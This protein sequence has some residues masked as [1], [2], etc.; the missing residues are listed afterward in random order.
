LLMGSRCATDRNWS[1]N[2]GHTGNTDKQGDLEARLQPACHTRSSFSVCSTLCNGLQHRAVL[3]LCSQPPQQL[4]LCCMH[5]CMDND[6][7]AIMPAPPGNH[8]HMHII[9]VAV[10]K[11]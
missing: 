3:C 2:L 7:H 6:T 9:A 10:Q 11:T 5:A 1:R 4:D 8:R